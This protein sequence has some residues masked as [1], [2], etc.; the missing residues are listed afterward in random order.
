MQ[1][2]STT[3]NMAST[4]GLFEVHRHAACIDTSV[5]PTLNR[6]L[7]AVSSAHLARHDDANYNKDTVHMCQLLEIYKLLL[8]W[9]EQKNE[10]Q[11]ILPAAKN[12]HD[13]IASEPMRRVANSAPPKR[14]FRTFWISVAS[15]LLK[16]ESKKVKS[17]LSNKIS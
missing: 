12:T 17:D 10:Q 2:V 1:G 6:E 7:T 4:L 13:E 14:F 16:R 5:P 9:N 3:L 8:F 15:R 11:A